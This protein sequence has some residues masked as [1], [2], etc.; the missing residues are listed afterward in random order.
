MPLKRALDKT[1]EF[2]ELFTKKLEF[3]ENKCEL[4]NILA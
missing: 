3:T 1:L 4:S 2:I